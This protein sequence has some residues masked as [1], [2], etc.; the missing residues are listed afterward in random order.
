MSGP[1]DPSKKV[2]TGAG[3]LLR[4]SKYD[5]SIKKF[6]CTSTHKWLFSAGSFSNDFRAAVAR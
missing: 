2:P 3:D 1:I 4:G 5:M 6:V